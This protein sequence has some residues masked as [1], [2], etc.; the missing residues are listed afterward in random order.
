M[1]GRSCSLGRTLFFEAQPLGVDE[2]PDRRV[3]DLDAASGQFRL[4]AAQ[5]EALA[6]RH[7]RKKP[8][9]VRQ[10]QPGP[11]A[12][13]RRGGHA[14]VARKRR[15]PFTTLAKLTCKTAATDRMLS[16]APPRE[17]ARSRKS[18]E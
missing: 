9:A 16:P 5:G 1:S 8:V 6:V 13:H 12:M 17:T 7:A 14:P 15:Y 4:K 10:Q 11:M 2:V 18:N 3:I